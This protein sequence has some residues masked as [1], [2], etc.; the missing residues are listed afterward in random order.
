MHICPGS[1]HRGV[2]SGASARVRSADV[3][4]ERQWYA[5]FTVPQNEKSVAKHLALR[6]IESFL[7]TYETVRVWK[8]RQRVKVVLPLF[9][10]Y[11]FV[12]IGSHDRARVL[13]SPGVLQIVGNSRQ[14]LPLPDSDIEFLKSD[15]CRE[16]TEPYR[17]LVV[18]EKVRVCRGLMQGVEGVLVRKNNS[19]RFVLTLGLI[20]QHAA[21]EV[22]AGDLELLCA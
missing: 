21:I 14:P 15:F 8:N 4:C 17:E 20:N 11:I 19:L 3:A 7:P 6:D 12:R 5:V 18:G 10:T 9:P 16:R 1:T 2:G 13:Q 22:N